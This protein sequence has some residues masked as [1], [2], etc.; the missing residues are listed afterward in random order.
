MKDNELVGGKRRYLFLLPAFIAYSAIII[1][2]AFYSFYLSFFKWNGIAA[3]KIF[4]GFSNYTNLITKDETFQIA[5]KN[6]VI[7]VI[8][9]IVFTICISLLFAMLINRQFQG[10]TLLRAVLYFPF[11]LSTVI[12][13]IT[14]AWV[15]QP[16][17]GL[18][19]GIMNL[20]GLPQFT[21]SWL[22]DIDSAFFAVFVASCWHNIGSP[23]ILF[24]AGLQTIPKELYEAA[25]M[26]GANKVQ[27]FLH[28][29][30]PRL[31]ETFVIVG[32]TQIISALKVYDLI[33]TMTNGGPANQTQTVATYMV[34]QSF[35]YANVG[36]GSAM[37]WILVFVLMIIVIPYII[38]MAKE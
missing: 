21:K 9:T 14:W 30:I 11:V 7:W 18:F 13:A 31:H 27:T 38:F 15:Y 24:L 16:Q 2:P 5:I 4:V 25:V 6:N 32:A 12:V 36:I 35:T 22:A 1:A 19:N 29:T 10:R 34:T 33:R 28:I 26:D 23:M 3:K 37:A 8:L 20:L 17:L